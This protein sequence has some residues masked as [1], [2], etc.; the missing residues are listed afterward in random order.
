MYGSLLAVSAQ[1]AGYQQASDACKAQIQTAIRSTVG[2]EKTE[3]TDAD[4]NAFCPADAETPAVTC[5]LADARKRFTDVTD[6]IT[7]G[8]DA[9]KGLDATT[10]GAVGTV[11]D[12]VTDLGNSSLPLPTRPRPCSSS[13]PGTTRARSP[14]STPRSSDLRG[15]V[16]EV[17]DALDNLTGGLQKIHDQA[18]DHRREV[19]SMSD[20][21]DALAKE[22]CAVVGRGHP[23]RAAE[24]RSTSNGSAPTWSAGPATARP[25]S[26]PGRVA[27]RR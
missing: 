21:G 22:L 17:D 12:G 4:G 8:Q 14:G 24:R 26:T 13:D 9:S 18:D 16:A 1:L 3:G 2:P 5:S 20:Q 23:A 25:T 19:A 15:S 27:V 11:G 10:L 6:S 7:D